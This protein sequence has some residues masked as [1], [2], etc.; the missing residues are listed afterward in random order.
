MHVGFEQMDPAKIETAV[1]SLRERVSRVVACAFGAG[2]YFANTGII[3]IVII[4]I[5]IL[6]CY[7]YYY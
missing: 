3:I 4:I 5:I 1:G 2:V 7:Y 6:S